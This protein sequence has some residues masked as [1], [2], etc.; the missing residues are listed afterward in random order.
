M[1]SDA[2]GN[3][4]F[5]DTELSGVVNYGSPIQTVVPVLN[6]QG[7]PI[8]SQTITIT[9]NPIIVPVTTTIEITH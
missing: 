2:A 6:Q 4:T 9:P 5:R 1:G 3:T 8:G 7:Q